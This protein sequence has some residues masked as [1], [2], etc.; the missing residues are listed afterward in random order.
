MEKFISKRVRSAKIKGRLGGLAA[1]KNKDQTYLT[2]RASNAGLTTRDKYGI[3]YY[4]YLRGLRPKLK[5]TREKAEQIIRSV[6]PS[7]EP[8]PVNTVSLMQAAA[9]QLA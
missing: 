4:R 5:T 6:V 1:A 2:Q 7:S 3:E 9:K 8:L